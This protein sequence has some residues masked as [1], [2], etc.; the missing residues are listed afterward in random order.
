MYSRFTK[1]DRAAA[2]GP[3]RGMRVLMLATIHFD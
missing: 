2:T 3:F 1:P